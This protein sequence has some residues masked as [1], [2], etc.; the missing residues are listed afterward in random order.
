M[1]QSPDKSLPSLLL[2]IALR[3]VGTHALILLDP[4]GVIIGWFG[5]AQRIFGYTADEAR[6]KNI[7]I[8]FTP[9]DLQR[10]IPAWELSTANTAPES[11]DDRWQ[12]R[13][14]GGRI[15]VS[16]TLTA[17]RD[18]AGA[19][20][21]FAK[22][23]RNRTDQKIQFETLEAQIDSFQ[24]ADQR[25]NDFIATLAHE[26]RNPLTAITTAVQLL[27]R[28]ERA[29]ADNAFAVGIVRRQVDFMGQMINDLLDVARNAAGKVELRKE[30]VVLQEIVRHA[31]EVCQPKIDQHTH[32]IFPLL[33]E[34]PIHLNADPVRLRQVFVNLIENAVK[35]TQY[36]G[37]IWIKGSA[38][39]EEAVVRVQDNGIGIDPQF[40]P[41]IFNLFA[42]ANLAPTPGGLG[43]GLSVVKKIVSMH[44]GTV[45]AYSDGIG[46]GAEYVVRLPLP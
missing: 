42:Q 28:G 38:E 5:G 11:E 21:G 22:I 39:A 7:A 9:E 41:H 34:P 37:T 30:R 8:I 1:P 10:D 36:G 2:D 29:S 25:K 16:G 24:H 13:K 35:Y 15:W 23:I 3:S 43:I 46:K 17:L 18:E 44:G 32:E 14:D 20:L 33:P 26:L 31:I 19:L 6:G 40:M 45:Q 27:T 4:A 12:L